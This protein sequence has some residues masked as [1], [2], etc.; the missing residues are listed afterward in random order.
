MDAQR[1]LERFMLAL[2]ACCCTVLLTQRYYPSEVPNH[3]AA[4]R[5]QSAYFKLWISDKQELT[6]VLEI[7]DLIPILVH[8]GIDVPPSLDKI[9]VAPGTSLQN[10]TAIFLALPSKNQ[11]SMAIPPSIQLISPVDNQDYALGQQIKMEAKVTDQQCQI[12]KVEV[13]INDET[14]GP[15]PCIGE[16]VSGGWTP[17]VEGTNTITLTAYNEFGLASSATAFN[18]TV[19][20]NYPP[21][22]EIPQLADN[23]TFT[24]GV[25]YKLPVSAADQNKDDAVTD[26]TLLINGRPVK[27][28]TKAPYDFALGPLE[29]G[30]YTIHAQARE[31]HGTIGES[32][33]YKVYVK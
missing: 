6:N 8:Y 14:I 24:A 9:V 12:I 17:G 32:Y 28:L 7:N 16:N 26:V 11:Y 30:I 1:K 2:L 15:L 33:I 18:V 25:T 21:T 3:D 10:G 23:M 13:K 27:T 31:Q 29:P 22:V 4:Y 19:H 20:I 5:L